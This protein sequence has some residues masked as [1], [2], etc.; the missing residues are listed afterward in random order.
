M[1]LLGKSD[2]ISQVSGNIRYSIKQIK[3]NLSTSG[4][5]VDGKVNKSIKQIKGTL[6]LPIT[7]KMYT[8]VDTKTTHINVDNSSGIISVD[9]KKVPN[10]LTINTVDGDQIIYDGSQEL[11]ITLADT[12]TVEELAGQIVKNKEDIDTIETILPNKQDL[13]TPD[14]SIQIT[15]ENDVTNIS[16]TFK[17]NW[18]AFEISDWI[19]FNANQLRLVI[20]FSTHHFE[21]PTIETMYIYKFSDEDNEYSWNN[22]IPIFSVLPDKTLVIKSNEAIKCKVLIKGDH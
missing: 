2:N 21:M 16:T 15:K 3:S 22:S 19:Q 1:A 14:D 18:L 20:P 5:Q 11:S 17:S 7:Q 12:D 4:N 8:G 10:A 13:L 6:N 9:V